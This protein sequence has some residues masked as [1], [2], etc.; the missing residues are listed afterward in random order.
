MSGKREDLEIVIGANLD[1]LA[2]DLNRGARMMQSFAK[3]IDKHTPKAKDFIGDKD[4]AG[5]FR[6]KIR[7]ARDLS[8]ATK[9]A[10]KDIIAT[11]AHFAGFATKAALAGGALLGL[12]AGFHGVTGAMSKASNAIDLAAQAEQTQL[13]FEVML[14]SAEKAQDVLAGLRK[15]ASST[16]F[17]QADVIG[18]GRQLLG[19]DT[20]AGQ[21]IPTVRMLG[22]VAAGTGKNLGE[23][24]YLYG[25]LMQQD[26]A[27]T[28]TG[29]PTNSGQWES[30]V[31]SN[32]KET[33][34]WL[35]SA[36]FTRR[37]SSSRR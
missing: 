11:G 19:Y 8:V 34:R 35:V 24:T 27:Y 6:N 4:D 15:F 26:R 12:E 28:D 2:A 16:P 17:S 1:G 14:G 23:L 20:D 7:F 18:S 33:H 9:Q 29:V 36:R 25:T 22:D 5:F 37:S 31:D 3:D 21:I 13:A 32:H 10:G 30:G